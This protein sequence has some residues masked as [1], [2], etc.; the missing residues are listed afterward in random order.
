MGECM[1]RWVVDCESTARSVPLITGNIP[2]M[3][4][5]F[6]RAPL[7]HVPA[8][9]N[10]ERAH[11]ATHSRST[12]MGVF[13]ESE[14]TKCTQIKL[15]YPYTCALAR[16]SGDRPWLCT[17]GI[18]MCT[19]WP[20]GIV[21]VRNWIYTQ[22]TFTGDVTKTMWSTMLLSTDTTCALR[23][24]STCVHNH[25]L[26]VGN[27]SC[28]RRFRTHAMEKE[29]FSRWLLCVC[30]VCSVLPCSTSILRCPIRTAINYSVKGRVSTE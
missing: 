20:L 8:V 16:A 28:M 21:W 6:A 5:V 22:S 4:H 9:H 3:T 1:C 2:L 30:V 7:L 15:D 29:P 11:P 25:S 19:L 12:L 27:S 26:R 14:N 13:A 17:H 18:T 24:H 10:N 23:N